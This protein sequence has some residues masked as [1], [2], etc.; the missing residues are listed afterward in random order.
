MCPEARRRAWTA[1]PGYPR[2]RSRRTKQTAGS[3]DSLSDFLV[4]THPLHPLT[5]KR[6]P[7]LFTRRYRVGGLVYICEGGPGGSVALAEGFTDRGAPPESR[8]LTA[9]VLKDLHDVVVALTLPLTALPSSGILCTVGTKET[10]QQ[11]EHGGVADTSGATGAQP[12]AARGRTPWSVDHP[13]PAVRQ[14]GLSVHTG[15]PARSICVPDGPAED[16]TTSS[17]HSG[18]T[19]RSGASSGGAHH[20]H[21]GNAGRDLGDQSGVADPRG[22]D[23][24]GPRRRA[25]RTRGAAGQHARGRAHRGSRA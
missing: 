8:P 17:V 10:P 13:T 7:I 22:A 4:V 18:G 19:G 25:K 21:R 3:A 24:S 2:R 14:A 16:G 15:G 20:P 6:L 5:A 9:A 11:A 12:P 1:C 23:L